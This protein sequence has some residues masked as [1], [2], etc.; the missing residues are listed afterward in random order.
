MYLSMVLS[1]SSVGGSLVSLQKISTA[2]SAECQA[3]SYGG[4]VIMRTSPAAST[5]IAPGERFPPAADPSAACPAAMGPPESVDR[6]STSTSGLT[7]AS[8]FTSTG[9]SPCFA[10]EVAAESSAS[11][12]R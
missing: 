12:E 7:S 5:L 9:S 1:V 4:G 3:A 6:I 11:C 10:F 8:F 2:H